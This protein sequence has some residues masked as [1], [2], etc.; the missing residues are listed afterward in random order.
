MS[1]PIDP[2]WP[3]KMTP[4]TQRGDSEALCGYVN[5][6][7]WVHGGTPTIPTSEEETSDDQ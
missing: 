7:C 4:C 1:E 3:P 6:C 5:G 2:E